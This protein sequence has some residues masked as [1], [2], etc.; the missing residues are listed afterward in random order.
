MTILS[1]FIADVNCYLKLLLQSLVFM[2]EFI[3]TITFHSLLESTFRMTVICFSAII[4][5]PV[6]RSSLPTRYRS[7]GRWLNSTR[8]IRSHVRR[9]RTVP[10]S[11][12][13]VKGLLPRVSSQGWKSRQ[14]KVILVIGVVTATVR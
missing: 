9:G 13:L 5:R 1:F 10:S 8:V 7:W 2:S 4:T 6:V 14:I 12:T 11:V 3:T